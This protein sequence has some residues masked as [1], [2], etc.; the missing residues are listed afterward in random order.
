MVGME[1]TVEGENRISTGLASIMVERVGWFFARW[2]V[3]DE[4][5]YACKIRWL[6]W[7]L[8]SGKIVD[9][10]NICRIQELCIPL[11]QSAS[12]HS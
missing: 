12:I 1:V 9:F 3:D 5:L 11:L 10:V 8:D 6:A 2:A 7:L 4:I